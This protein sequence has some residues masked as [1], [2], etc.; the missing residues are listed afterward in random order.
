[1]FSRM[2][3]FSVEFHRKLNHFSAL[4]SIEHVLI[5]ESGRVNF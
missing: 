3:H 5:D 4:D 2:K 1:M